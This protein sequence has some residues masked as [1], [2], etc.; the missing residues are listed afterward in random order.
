M[1]GFLAQVG[2]AP[3][4]VKPGV[5]AGRCALRAQGPSGALVWGELRI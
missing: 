3:A 4:Y 5:G 1:K 2:E